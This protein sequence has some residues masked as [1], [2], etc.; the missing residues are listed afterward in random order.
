[1]REDLFVKRLTICMLLLLLPL[2]ALA[3]E[4]DFIVNNPHSTWV[5]LRKEPTTQS[6]SLGRYPNGTEITVLG[7]TKNGW[8]QLAVEGKTGYMLTGMVAR[9]YSLADETRVVGE[10]ADGAYIQALE[11]PNGQ[12]LYFTSLE[13]KPMI[14]MEDVNFDGISDIVMFVARGASNDFCEFFLSDGKTYHRAQ[15]PGMDQGICNYQLIPDKECLVSYANNG[16]AGALHEKAIFRWK[17]HHQLKLIRRAISQELTET[18]WQDDRFTITTYT[19]KLHLSI[20][21]YTTGEAGG[22]V[23]WEE[24]AEI[25]DQLSDCFAREE[26]ALWSGI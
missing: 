6:E 12:L 24:I 26:A 19:E 2:C 18:D 1:M 16:S 13:Q 14:K 22:V 3:Q 20:R 7:E 15:H 4:G 11:A 21:D 17:G 10:T 9:V 8:Y 25:D 5:H 23:I